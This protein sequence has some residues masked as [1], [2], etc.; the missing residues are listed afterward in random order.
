MSFLFFLSMVSLICSKKSG[1]FART[2]ARSINTCCWKHAGAA[3]FAKVFALVLF[4][5]FTWVAFLVIF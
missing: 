4:V 5:L 2:T 3:S 1:L